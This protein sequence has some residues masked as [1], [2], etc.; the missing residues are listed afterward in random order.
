MSVTCYG[1]Y[2][3]YFV[4][5][6]MDSDNSKSKRGK[7]APLSELNICSINICG[8][9]DRSQLCLDKFC[10]DKQ[11]DILAVQESFTVNKENLNLNQIPLPI[12]KILYC[13]L[14]YRYMKSG[15][16]FQCTISP[17]QLRYN[18]SYDL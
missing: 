2:M 4:F 11:L 9:S 15:G 3:A 8:M 13:K 12:F 7:R 6:N 18:P 17:K 14:F 1:H 10:S 5:C 16:I